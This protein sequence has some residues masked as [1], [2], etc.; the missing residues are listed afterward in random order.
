MGDLDT[1]TEDG[2]Q[3]QATGQGIAGEKCLCSEGA[4]GVIFG[5]M[6]KQ[7][8]SSRQQGIVMGCPRGIFCMFLNLGTLALGR[9]PEGW[10]S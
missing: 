1:G 4:I 8:R 7:P 9:G 5:G 10:K 2:G 3:Y 6:G